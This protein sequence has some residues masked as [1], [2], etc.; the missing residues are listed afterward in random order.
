MTASSVLA[1][2]SAAQAQ[3]AS[4]NSISTNASRASER[5]FGVGVEPLWLLIGGLG[6]EFDARVSEGTAIILAGMYVPTRDSLTSGSSADL[7]YKWTTYEVYIG[8]KFMLSGAYH[9]SGFY[10]APAVG[11]VGSTITD[12]GVDKW[13]GSLNA[14]VGRLTGGYQFVGFNGIRLT[15]GLGLRVASSS[16]IVIRDASDRDVYRTSSSSFGSLA[17]DLRFG[18]MF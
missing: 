9:E 6:A 7:N 10:L 5:S 11:Y 14:P 4:S 13:R 18:F 8:P 2:G 1:S 12:Y 17:L 3:G 16:D 15:T